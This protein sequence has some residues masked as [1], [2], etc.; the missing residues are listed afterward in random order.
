[1]YDISHVQAALGRPRWVH[2][3]MSRFFVTPNEVRGLVR[4][5]PLFTR[6]RAT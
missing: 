1:M 2:I 5:L 6:R 3:A 4:Q